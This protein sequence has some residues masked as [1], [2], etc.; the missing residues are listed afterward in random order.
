MAAETQIVIELVRQPEKVQNIWRAVIR[1]NCLGEP[2]T[3]RESWENQQ[4]RLKTVT[5]ELF[6]QNQSELAEFENNS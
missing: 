6:A 4:K 3:N 1:D 2:E 5:H